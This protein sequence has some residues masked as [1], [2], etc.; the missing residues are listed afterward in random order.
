MRVCMYVHTHTQ[1]CSYIDE[2]V[3]VYIFGGVQVRT[4]CWTSGLLEG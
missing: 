2:C 4:E 1:I 3:Y